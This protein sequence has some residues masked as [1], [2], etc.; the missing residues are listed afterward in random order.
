[1]IR[2]ILQV[3]IKIN[4]MTDEQLAK[5]MEELKE[6]ISKLESLGIEDFDLNMEAMMIIARLV[7]EKKLD[8]SNNE[9]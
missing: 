3:A 5:R 9:K 7:D 4:T 2:K 1:M 6:N 8:N